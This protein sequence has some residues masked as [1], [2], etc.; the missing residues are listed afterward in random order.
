LADVLGLPRVLVRN[1]S[2]DPDDFDLAAA[3]LLRETKARRDEA[4][5]LGFE[6]LGFLLGRFMNLVI[7]T[8]KQRVALSG[9]TDADPSENPDGKPDRHATP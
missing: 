2:E 4:R 5:Q 7:E 6:H 9:T 3:R 1:M 8:W